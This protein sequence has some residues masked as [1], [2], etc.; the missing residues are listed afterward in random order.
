MNGLDR[1]AVHPSCDRLVPPEI[2]LATHKHLHSAWPAWCSP[3]LAGRAHER[4]RDQ[5]I[6][7]QP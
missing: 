5:L 6:Y 1:E 4:R 7:Y 2:G 3:A